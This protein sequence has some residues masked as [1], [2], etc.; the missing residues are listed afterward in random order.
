MR[1]D[2]IEIGGRER[3][4]EM[5]WNAIVAYLET[6]GQND[7]QALSSLSNLK[8][9][10][11]A[12]LMAAAINEGES[13]EGRESN[14]TAQDIG[15]MEGAIGAISKFLEIFVRQMNPAIGDQSDG[16]KE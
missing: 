2:F 15:R 1:K 5:N 3:R 13:L 9:T 8:P 7:L 16:K 12:G 10:D 6:S 4:V 14:L 11:L